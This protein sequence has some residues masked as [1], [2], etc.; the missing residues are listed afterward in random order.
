MDTKTL[1]KYFCAGINSFNKAGQI[2]VMLQNQGYPL[3]EIS[4][5]SEIL[6]IANLKQLIEVYEGRLLPELILKTPARNYVR[7]L[8]VEKQREVVRNGVEVVRPQGT[9]LVKKYV[10]YSSLKLQ[11]CRVAFAGNKLRSE[12]S[13]RRLL[14]KG[15]LKRPVYTV[16]NGRVVIHRQTSFSPKEIKQMLSEVA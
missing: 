4:R 12:T 3:T 2:V 6:T 10:P 1:N 13:Q 14:K 8:P 15:V 11:D 5:K 7:K 9:K 16:Y